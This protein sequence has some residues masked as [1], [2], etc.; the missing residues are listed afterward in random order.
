[1]MKTI[2]SRSKLELGDYYYKYRKNY[3]AAKVLYNEAITVYPDSA[4]ATEAHKKLAVIDAKLGIVPEGT[5]TTP[6]GPTPVAPK[7]KKKF[8]GIF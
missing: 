2:L 3:K 1:K 4:V 7:K 8:L 6:A 5:A